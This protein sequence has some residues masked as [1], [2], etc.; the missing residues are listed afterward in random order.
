MD[1]PDGSRQLELRR[2]RWTKER[3]NGRM[4]EVEEGADSAG[5]DVKGGGD[6]GGEVEHLQ[7]NWPHLN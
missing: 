1:E 3:G 4:E 5:G 6:E 7:V 2:Q